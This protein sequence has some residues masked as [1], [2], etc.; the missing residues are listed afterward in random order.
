[1]RLVPFDE[2]FIFLAGMEQRLAGDGIAA[3]LRGLDL[4]QRFCERHRGDCLLCVHGT[5]ICN[6]NR[7]IFRE[8]RVLVI[9]LQRPDESLTQAL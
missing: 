3:G 8:N 2:C 7:R 9:E 5:A 6:E 1:M 4:F